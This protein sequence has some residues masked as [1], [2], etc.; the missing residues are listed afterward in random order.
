MRTTTLL[1]DDPDH[2]D[3]PT[4]SLESPAWTEDDRSLMLALQQDEATLCACGEPRD[5]AWHSEL[6]GWYEVEKFVCHACT[7]SRGDQV[8]YAIARNDYPFDEMPPLRLF[9]LGVTTTP[10]G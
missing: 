4:G 2:P 5:H 8:V 6:E 3:R 7:A 10:P 1:Y 9:E